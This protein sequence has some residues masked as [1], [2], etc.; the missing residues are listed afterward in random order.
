MNTNAT[1][2]FTYRMR[3]HQSGQ[4]W[5]PAAIWAFFVIVI[6][7]FG[8]SIPSVVEI[9]ISYIGVVL[10]LLGGILGAYAILD[11]PVLELHFASPRSAI[12]M[13][14]ERT[15]IIFGLL[16][17]C[18]ITFQVFLHLLAVDLN[19]YGSIWTRQLA[20]IIPCLTLTMLGAFA[21][22]V[23]TQSTTGAMLVGMIWIVQLVARGWFLGDPIAR[24]FFLFSGAL[25][26]TIGFLNQNYIVLI[27]LGIV[28][29]GS[30]WYLLKNQERF[31]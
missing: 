16:T 4:F 8:K 5:L 24:Y 2:P 6:G 13:L 23:S 1:I 29:F 18:A 11:D 14:L 20:W 7:F 17:I 25:A 10:P 31:I 28:F 9:S 30:A 21:A 26:P 15:I 22:F 19:P 27:A 3:T 12:Q